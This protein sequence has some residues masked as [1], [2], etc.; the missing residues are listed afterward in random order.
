[1]GNQLN[2]PLTDKVLADTQAIAEIISNK[3]F[4]KAR[5]HILSL[6]GKRIIFNA[7]NYNLKPIGG[8]PSKDEV[9]EINEF[10][11]INEPT[12]IAAIDSS[13]IHIADVEDGAVYAARIAC[14]FFY[15]REPKNHIRI[16]PIIFYL[17]E[18]NLDEIMSKIS[19]DELFSKLVLFDETMAQSMIRVKLERTFVMEL[20]KI[21]SGS[22]IMID[23][24]LR[25]SLFDSRGTSL[26]DIMFEAKKQNNKI[27]GISKSSKHRILNKLSSEFYSIY[28]AP[29]YAD[30][31]QMISPIF[32]GVEGRIFLVK[33]TNDGLV[34]RV[35]I[36]NF[37]LT[38]DDILSKIRYNDCF[39]GGYPESLRLAHHH[40]LLTRSEDTSIQSYLSKIGVIE[41]SAEDPRKI[42]L[43]SLKFGSFGKGTF[44]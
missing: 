20:T 41:H 5:P 26:K 6:S 40:C 2:F 3:I 10:S 16:G 13:C 19:K 38:F 18:D 36:G 33:F 35:D 30:I 12:I 17:N 39:F 34:F 22:I 11:T 37:D 42:V 14:V 23:G 15:N 8:W 21:L 44:R 25:N 43:G 7:D 1:M 24:A 4:I 32:K 28:S 29:V 31:H 27:L 9:L